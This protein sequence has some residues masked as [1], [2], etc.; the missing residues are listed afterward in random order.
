M[1]FL[2]FC[3]TIHVIIHIFERKRTEF[4]FLSLLVFFAFFVSIL[5]YCTYIYKVMSQIKSCS[6]NVL[7]KNQ[8]LWSS[9]LS[10]FFARVVLLIVVFFLSYFILCDMARKKTWCVVNCYFSYLPLLLCFSSCVAHSN[11][12]T[13]TQVRNIFFSFLPH[14]S[15]QQR[16]RRGNF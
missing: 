4:V 9:L 3:V 13:Q 6:R 12:H 16:L 2:L 11:P 15:Q 7:M 1:F 8:L 10:L 5:L 14:F